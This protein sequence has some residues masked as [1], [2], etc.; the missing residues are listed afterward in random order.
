MAV[1]RRCFDGFDPRA[2]KTKKRTNMFG[3]T[4]ILETDLNRILEELKSAKKENLILA[5][6]TKAANNARNILEKLVREDSERVRAERENERRAIEATEQRLNKR[7]A[8]MSA[9]APQ[10][11]GLYLF[12]D[13]RLT[14]LTEIRDCRLNNAQPYLD[15]T[16]EDDLH[17]LS[18]LFVS[19]IYTNGTWGSVLSAR[20]RACDFA[21]A[22]SLVTAGGSS[23]SNGSNGNRGGQNSASGVAT[24]KPAS[25]DLG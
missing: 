3:L 10:Y 25:P 21:T 12:G 6:Q 18:E 8:E 17:A 1:G 20:V 5:E 16:Q 2:E 24:S 11:P 15:G 4:T 13:E 9:L 23:G 22:W 19:E 14:P 7:A